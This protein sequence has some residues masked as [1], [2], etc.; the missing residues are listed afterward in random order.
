MAKADFVE[1]PFTESTPEELLRGTLAGQ[2]LKEFDENE[3][4]ERRKTMGKVVNRVARSGMSPIGNA[5]AWMKGAPVLDVIFAIGSIT[6][7]GLAGRYGW[8]GALKA[9]KYIR[10]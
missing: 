5:M 3:D 1:I 4:P 8:L 7:V 6:S 2:L 9:V 10:G